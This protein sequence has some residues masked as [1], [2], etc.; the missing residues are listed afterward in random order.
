MQER[1]KERG[2]EEDYRREREVRGKCE[3]RASEM[4]CKSVKYGRRSLL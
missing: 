3:V 2:K 4:S 1:E